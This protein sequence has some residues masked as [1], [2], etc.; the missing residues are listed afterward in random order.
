MT[1]NHLGRA[2]TTPAPR[3]ARDCWRPHRAG[4]RSLR[5]WC[6]V[7]LLAAAS[8]LF[9]ACRDLGQEDGDG[10]STTTYGQAFSAQQILDQQSELAATGLTDSED[11]VADAEES[12]TDTEEPDLVCEDEPLSHWLLVRSR[13]AV[14][15]LIN[16]V[17]EGTSLTR[18][19]A[20]QSLWQAAIDGLE[21]DGRITTAL[22]TIL[23]DREPVIADLAYR[24]LADLE[25]FHSP[26][27]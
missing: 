16:A 10:N 19:E 21:E 26:Q 6:I 27:Y 11:A 15:C 1:R 8:L 2:S 14:R 12:T 5:L 4:L 23:H 17:K 20:A 18:F 9:G 3:W 22:N 13:A 7:G 24:A 25:A